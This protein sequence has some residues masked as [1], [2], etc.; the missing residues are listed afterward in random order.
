MS[1][2][3][4]DLLARNGYFHQDL[5]KAGP[6]LKIPQRSATECFFSCHSLVPKISVPSACGS[7]PRVGNVVTELLNSLGLITAKGIRVTVHGMCS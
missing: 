7:H 3:G 5:S 1:R 2:D 4:K 6:G